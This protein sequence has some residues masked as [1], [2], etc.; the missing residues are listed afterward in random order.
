[1]NVQIGTRNIPWNIHISHLVGGVF[2]SKPAADVLFGDVLFGQGDD[3]H[4]TD[5]L[6]D[7]F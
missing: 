4:G 2:V 1:M 3:L 7:V 6:S 5:S